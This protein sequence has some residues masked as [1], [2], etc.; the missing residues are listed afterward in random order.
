MS[1]QELA[2]AG[3]LKFVDP[4]SASG[5]V[6]AMVDEAREGGRLSGAEAALFEALIWH[7]DFPSHLRREESLPGMIVSYST[8]AGD[9][10][11]RRRLC[12]R[13]RKK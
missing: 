3:C 4:R 2:S 5:L 12:T 8:A 9:D 10:S 11:V 7:P 1:D 6:L 13:A